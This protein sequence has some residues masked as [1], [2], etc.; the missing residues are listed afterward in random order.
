MTTSPLLQIWAWPLVLA[1][2]SAT[3]LITALVS[4]AWGDAWA[5][6]ALGVPLAAMAWFG[7]RSS[8]APKS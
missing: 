6:F 8:S 3:G 4:D 1:L 7:L 2:L 5:W